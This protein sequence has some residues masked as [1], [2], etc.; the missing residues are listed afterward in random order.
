L[1]NHVTSANHIAG[2]CKLDSWLQEHAVEYEMRVEK[3][4]NDRGR[5]QWNVTC[6]MCGVKL[7]VTTLRT[8]V[9]HVSCEKHIRASRRACAGSA[10]VPGRPAAAAS[11][12]EP[13][14]PLRV[15]AARGR[16]VLPAALLARV[17]RAEQAAVDEAVALVFDGSHGDDAEDAIAATRGML[18][19]QA[20]AAAAGVFYAA[21][22]AAPDAAPV[23]SGD[24]VAL[25]ADEA[26]PVAGTVVFGHDERLPVAQYMSH[27]CASRRQ[28]DVRVDGPT[29]RVV[30]T[31]YGKN[32]TV[33]NGVRLADNAPVD[34]PLVRPSGGVGTEFRI[35]AVIRVRPHRRP[36]DPHILLVA[37]DIA[38]AARPERLAKPLGMLNVQAGAAAAATA[39]QVAVSGSDGTS[40]PPSK[41]RRS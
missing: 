22:S 12:A 29:G 41:R 17:L 7:F 14:P 34:V 3:V 15:D 8:L 40:R 9:A 31:H 1:E 23:Q 36:S 5:T 30:V 28:L 19:V 33:V 38:A 18:N 4:V 32:D 16:R 2:G 25:G 35:V 13:P 27:R 37:R 6:G 10:G 11:V 26:H 24:V 39:A 20:A 21:R